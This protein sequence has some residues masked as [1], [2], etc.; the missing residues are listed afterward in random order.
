MAGTRAQSPL[1]PICHALKRARYGMSCRLAV[2]VVGLLGASATSKPVQDAVARPPTVIGSFHDY[3]GLVHLHTNYSGD[4]VGS[5]ESIARAAS[6]DHVDFLISAD[7]NNL[8]ALADG[9]EGWHGRTLFIPGVESSRPEGYLLVLNTRTYTATRADGTDA[10]LA[11]TARQGGMTV[12]AHPANAKWNWKGAIDDRMV[13]M[14]ILNLTDVFQ[15]ASAWTK[16]RAALDYPLNTLSAYLDLY[17][18]PGEALRRWD[19]VTAKRKF[20]GLYAPDFHQNV[21]VGNARLHVPPAAE[22]M[23]FARNHILAGTAFTGD[24]RHDKSIVYEA[25]A[26]GRLYVSIDGLGH[27]EGFLFSGDRG[28]TSVVMGGSLDGAGRTTFCV[29]LPPGSARL[30]PTI[31]L[32]R[33]G[34]EIARGGTPGTSFRHDDDRAGTYRVEVTVPVS[35]VWRGTREIPWIYSNPIYVG[36]TVVAERDKR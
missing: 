2:L 20:V 21:Y 22:V 5:V 9:E 11:D 36:S 24:A 4:A 10:L 26:T 18:R 30:R 31:H 29:D 19:A 16:V 34:V 8:R 25:I 3:N 15:S 12:V 1:K 13:G 32:Y 17:D 35:T 28:G 33:N 23:Q 14:E 6:R 7:H 27:P